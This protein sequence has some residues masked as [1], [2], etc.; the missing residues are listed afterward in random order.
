M[1]KAHFVS[2]EAELPQTVHSDEIHSPNARS[3]Q[4]CETLD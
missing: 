1:N 2:L 4:Q 3:L